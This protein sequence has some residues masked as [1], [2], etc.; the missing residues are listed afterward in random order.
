MT[1]CVGSSRLEARGVFP[2]PLRLDFT[3]E[4]DH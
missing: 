2:S 3:A 1:P 4:L